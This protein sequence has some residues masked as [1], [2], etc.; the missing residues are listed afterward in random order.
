MF[1][2]VLALAVAF[3]FFPSENA[4]SGQVQAY[5]APE[6]E[7]ALV[8]MV[9]TPPLSL[10]EQKKINKAILQKHF[11]DDPTMV[12]IALAESQYCT[13]NV[14]PSSTA[15]GCFQI[16]KGTF[17]DPAYKCSGDRMDIEDNIACA[18]KIRAKSG[19]SP[20][21]ASKHEWKD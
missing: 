14:N 16:L 12:R 10:A 8:P 17:N 7:M 4:S 6:E 5:V 19:Y 21:N 15:R 2:V 3:L 1:F 18:K 11:A 20:W 13:N 9:K